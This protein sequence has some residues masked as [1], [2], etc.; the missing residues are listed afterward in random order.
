MKF[1]S[2]T[3]PFC[4]IWC[5]EEVPFAAVLK[6]THV[7]HTSCRTGA[8]SRKKSTFPCLL[9]SGVRIRGVV[10]T[11]HCPSAACPLSGCTDVSPSEQAS[12][13]NLETWV[14]TATREAWQE[15]KH[16]RWGFQ[17]PLG[18]PWK[19]AC[20]YT[21]LREPSA[22]RKATCLVPAS[23]T[24][25][26]MHTPNKFKKWKLSRFILA[27]QST[28]DFITDLETK[29]Q[30]KIK[31]ELQAPLTEATFQ[32]SLAI[33]IVPSWPWEQGNDSASS[34]AP[35]TSKDTAIRCSSS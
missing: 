17:A 16:N 10:Q 14:L 34:T 23:L 11:A 13:G 8:S 1:L 19:P 35:G 20:T 12:S 21:T 6:R 27:K 30:Q 26:K 29:S 4:T 5:F 28:R 18:F 25:T 2:K 22:S 31:Q 24:R 3:F 9:W 15:I 32:L 33:F 7:Y